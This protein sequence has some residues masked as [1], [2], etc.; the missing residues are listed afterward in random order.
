VDRETKNKVGAQEKGV[1]KRKTIRNPRRMK[2][3][4]PKPKRRRV[5]D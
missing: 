2:S 4:S 3:L 1:P 5:K